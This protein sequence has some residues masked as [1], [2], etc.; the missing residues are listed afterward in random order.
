[1]LAQENIDRV[2]AAL[3]P[4]RPGMTPVSRGD[5]GGFHVM[6]FTGGNEQAHCDHLHAFGDTLLPYLK[7]RWR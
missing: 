7:E 4:P 3:P 6:G 2:P 5:S 1:L